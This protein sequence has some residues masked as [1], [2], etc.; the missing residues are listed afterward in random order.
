M[1]LTRRTNGKA[2]TDWRLASKRV[3][4]TGEMNMGAGHHLK[5]IQNQ[6]REK[7]TKTQQPECVKYELKDKKKIK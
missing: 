7:G 5:R 2:P 3:L 4:V 6:M 1:S